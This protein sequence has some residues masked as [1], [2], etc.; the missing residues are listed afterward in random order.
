MAVGLY[1]LPVTEDNI[2][3]G[4]FFYFILSCLMFSYF[5]KRQLLSDP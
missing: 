4:E 5:K 1:W 3:N 2:V